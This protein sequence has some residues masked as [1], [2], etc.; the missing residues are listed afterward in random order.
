M[1][2]LVMFHQAV[3]KKKNPENAGTQRNVQKL[4]VSEFISPFYKT[5]DNSWVKPCTC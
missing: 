3:S 5:R 1:V 4:V 2:S